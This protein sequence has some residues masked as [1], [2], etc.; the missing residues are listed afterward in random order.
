MRPVHYPTHAPNQERSRASAGAGARCP[1]RTAT[2]RGY[3]TESSARETE[4]PCARTERPKRDVF[5][6]PPH[7]TGTRGAAQTPRPTPTSTSSDA[8]GAN[9]AATPAPR[10]A[11]QSENRKSKQQWSRRIHDASRSFALPRLHRPAVAASGPPRQP[12]SPAKNEAHARPMPSRCSMEIRPR[13]PLN[14]RV[15]ILNRTKRCCRPEL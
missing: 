1:S 4:R 5:E 2:A 10:V 7:A 6:M 15:S 14:R 12:D 13:E 11:I 8:S 9:P 3:P